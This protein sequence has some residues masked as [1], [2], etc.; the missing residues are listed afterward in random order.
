MFCVFT[1]QKQVSFCHRL[2]SL[3]LLPAPQPPSLWWSPCCYL[4]LWGFVFVSL[5]PFTFTTRTPN[6]PLS[7]LSVC[8][9]VSVSLFLFYLINTK[10][11][12]RLASFID[13]FIKLAFGLKDSST[14]LFF[15]FSGSAL[16]FIIFSLL[17]ALGLSCSSSFLKWRLRWLIWEFYAL[18]QMF[19]GGNFLLSTSLAASYNF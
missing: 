11:S 9:S 13:L 7:K 5:N 10:S 15:C 6:P 1:T 12:S 3:Y 4:C 16:I 14:L 8:F 2:P 17:F 19:K 18:W